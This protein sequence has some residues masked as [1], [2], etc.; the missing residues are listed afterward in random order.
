MNKLQS[1][2]KTRALTDLAVLI[3]L[4]LI[5]SR[6]TIGPSFLKIGFS[7]V[8]IALIGYYFGPARSMLVGIVTDIL[9]NIL[10]PPQ[11]GFFWGFTLSAALLGWLY[12]QFLYE[13][14]IRWWRLL[15][16]TV[17][18]LLVVNLG[19]NTLWVSFLTKISFKTLFWMRLWKELLFIPIQTGVLIGVF[20]WLKKH[21]YTFEE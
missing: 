6:L 13:R 4:Q 17:V 11:G 10:F 7:F 2:T 16:V 8:I 20:H 19:C 1:I 15:A 9:G 5:L 21:H 14:P 12:G 18:S 3:A